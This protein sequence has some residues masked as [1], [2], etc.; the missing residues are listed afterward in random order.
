M[1]LHIY[2]FNTV[3]NPHTDQNSVNQRWTKQKKQFQYFI[4]TL[5]ITDD[6]CQ[7]TLLLHMVGQKTQDTFDTFPKLGKWTKKW[8]KTGFLSLIFTELVL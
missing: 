3:F 1:T 8:P 4:L 7:N 2:T 5:G 6:T